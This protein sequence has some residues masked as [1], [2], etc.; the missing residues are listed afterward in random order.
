MLSTIA[1]YLDTQIALTNRR[2]VAILPNTLLGVKPV[3]AARSNF[4]IE[5]I[6]G[7]SAAT[8]FDVLGA[9]VGASRS[10]SPLP[11]L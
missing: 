6:A 1:F 2:L 5:N 3:G 4:P 10:L 8:R 11:S 7:V 9:L